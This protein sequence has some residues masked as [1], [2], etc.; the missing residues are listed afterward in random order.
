MCKPSSVVN[1][2]AHPTRLDSYSARWRVVHPSWNLGRRNKN[3]TTHKCTCMCKLAQKLTHMKHQTNSTCYWISTIIN[4]K[5][6]KNLLQCSY[7]ILW[8]I[9]KVDLSTCLLLCSTIGC[10]SSQSAAQS[11][12][13][14][15]CF[16]FH[17]LEIFARKDYNLKSCNSQGRSGHG[18]S[19]LACL[20]KQRNG[21]GDFWDFSQPRYLNS[22]NH[23]H[24]FKSAC[25]YSTEGFRL[26]DEMYL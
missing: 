5:T 22:W 15:L 1:Y 13:I 14:L 8:N 10:W 26:R 12:P 6:K 21:T 2:I 18:L 24:F 23:S 25:L 19:G 20:W 16:Q 11:V 7:L 9:R 3:K 17:C 4:I